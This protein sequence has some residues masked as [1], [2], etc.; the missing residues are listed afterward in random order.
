VVNF[1]LREAQTRTPQIHFLAQGGYD[2][3]KSTYNDY[4]FVATGEKRFFDDKFGVFAEADAEQQNLSANE[5]GAGYTLNSPKL[6]VA[7][8]TY[9]TGVTLTDIPRTQ[10]RYDGTITMD[11]RLPEGKIDFMN[12]YSYGTTNEVDRGESFNLVDG[13]NNHVYTLQ[14]QQA[15]LTE[16][17]NILDFQNTYPF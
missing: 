17:T 7:N 1:N 6:G 15:Q 13:A 4:K 8:K 10:K 2:N 12:F 9:L 14:N 11:Y 16:I 5:L 3:L